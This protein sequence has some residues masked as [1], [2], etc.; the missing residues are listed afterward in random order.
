MLILIPIDVISTTKPVR[1]YLKGFIT[2]Y[3]VWDEDD[4]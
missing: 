2:H 3:G 4:E 1:Q